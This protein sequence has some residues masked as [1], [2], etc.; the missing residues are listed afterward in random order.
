MV[1]RWRCAKN[2]PSFCNTR[3]RLGWKKLRML[4]KVKRPT[5]HLCQPKTTTITK[6][7]DLRRTGV[8]ANLT[9]VQTPFL[10]LCSSIWDR[11][12]KRKSLILIILPKSRRRKTRT[13]KYPRKRLSRKSTLMM[14]ETVQF[15]T[16]RPKQTKSISMTNNQISL[17]LSSWI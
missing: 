1:W 14:A 15:T 5:W 12:S 3:S 13:I 7:M 8:Q 6:L 11:L 17:S 4:L 16:W 2:T 10:T 9:L